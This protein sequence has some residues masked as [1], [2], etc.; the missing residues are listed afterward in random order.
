MIQ[1]KGI[2]KTR[3]GKMLRRVLRGLLEHAVDGD[4]DKEVQIPAT[5]EDASLVEVTRTKIRQYFNERGVKL[6]RAT[7][8]KS[9]L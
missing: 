2:L 9:K 5:I 3:S 6:H 8:A 1:V 7:E 4:F